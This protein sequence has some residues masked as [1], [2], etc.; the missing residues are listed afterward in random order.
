MADPVCPKC[1]KTQA[2]RKKRESLYE[3]FLSLFGLYPW[4]C[5]A[6][7]AVFNTKKQGKRKARRPKLGDFVVPPQGKTTGLSESRDPAERPSRE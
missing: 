7:R 2:S 6:C 1:E 5:T 4:E 3:Y